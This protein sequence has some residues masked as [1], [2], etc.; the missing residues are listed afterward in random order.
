M[1]KKL[2]DQLEATIGDDEWDKSYILH[3]GMRK[4]IA[5]TLVRGLRDLDSP[6]RKTRHDALKW[7][8][9]KERLWIFSAYSCCNLLGLEV[10]ALQDFILHNWPEAR[11]RTG[12]EPLNPAV[13]YKFPPIPLKFKRY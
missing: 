5:A 11:R 6:D 4:L 3:K 13:V 12:Y 7:W 2:L 9:S 1:Q 8:F 10:Y